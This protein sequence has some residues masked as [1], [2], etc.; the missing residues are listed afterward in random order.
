MGKAR[1]KCPPSYSPAPGTGFQDD[2]HRSGPLIGG[3]RS[4]AFL[5]DSQ[6][7]VC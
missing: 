3:N 1:G 5:A 2:K 7:D 6:A 4:T